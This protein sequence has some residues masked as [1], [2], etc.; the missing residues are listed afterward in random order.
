MDRPKLPRPPK[1]LGKRGKAY[2][3]TVCERFDLDQTDLE[4]L[5]VACSLLDQ[6]DEAQQAIRRDGAFIEDRFGKPKEHPAAATERAAV[7]GFVKCVRELGLTADVPEESRGPRPGC[8][9]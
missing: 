5:A 3:K 2:W 7:A 6:Q 9:K 1:A 4:L 8:Y